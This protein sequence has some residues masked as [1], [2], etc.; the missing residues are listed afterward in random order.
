MM[1][2]RHNQTGT[3]P[4]GEHFAAPKRLRY[5]AR[6][7][8]PLL[9]THWRGTNVRHPLAGAHFPGMWCRGDRDYSHLFGRCAPHVA[10]DGKPRR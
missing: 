4:S 6:S 10:G 3:P 9:P 7:L 5:F 1:N 2:M 8:A